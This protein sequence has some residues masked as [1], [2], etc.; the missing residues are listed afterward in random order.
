MGP[1]WGRQDPGGPHVRPTNFATWV[2]MNR[3]RKFYP[4]FSWRYCCNVPKY[5]SIMYSLAVWVIHSVDI[6]NPERCMP[7]VPRAAVMHTYAWYNMMP[8]V[9]MLFLT[10]WGR[11]KTGAISQTTF[12][13]AFPWKKMFEFQLNFHWMLFPRVQLTMFR[14]WS[15]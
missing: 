3:Y 10:R 15:R 6:Q 12:S 8:C 14:H 11:H 2:V 1:I 7:S 9:M 13:N 4:R 5:I